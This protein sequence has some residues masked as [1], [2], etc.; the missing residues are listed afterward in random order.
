[1]SL[2]DSS[3]DPVVKIFIVDDSVFIRNALMDL[4]PGLGFEVVGMASTAKEAFKYIA[5]TRPNLVLLDITIP[6]FTPI[7]IIRGL[8]SINKSLEIIILAPLTN[9][10]QIANLLRAGARDYIPKPIVPRQIEYVL[11]SFELSLG[12]KPAT[13]IQTIA[14]LY[15]LFFNELLKCAPETVYK[16]I[17][18]AVGDPIKRLKRTYK[19]RYRIELSPLKIELLLAQDSHSEKVYRMYKNQLSRLYLSIVKKIGKELPKEYVFSLLSEAFHS[20]YPLARYLLEDLDFKFPIWE[21]FELENTHIDIR[22]D[23][24]FDYDYQSNESALMYVPQQDIDINE[25]LQHY[26]VIVNHD[27]RVTPKFPKSEMKNI[28]NFDLHLILSVFDDIIG[29]KT[30][31]IVPPPHGRLEKDKLQA[32]PRFMDMV[33]TS[34]GEPFIHSVSDYGTVNMIFSIA[35]QKVRGG[36]QAYM[37]S[38]AISPVEVRE[39]VKM[40]QLSALMRAVS[41][42][43]AN[44]Y[45]EF[46]ENGKRIISEPIKLLKEFL[47]EIKEFL[48][49]N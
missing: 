38:I 23:A 4:L 32:I 2:L 3:L 33:G 40:T 47:E 49:K 42:E 6:E 15:A 35:S 1:M 25:R 5:E 36:S 45:S 24:R 7:D 48:R 30:E 8:L 31:L 28:D 21:N 27:P 37:L 13:S 34:P 43:I 17:E 20:Y 29:P 41:A 9:Q 11:R 18:K 14:E 19:D 44:H 22:G 12:Y 26:K 16:Q 46:A 10:N 39:M